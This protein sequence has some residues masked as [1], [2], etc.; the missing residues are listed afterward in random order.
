MSTSTLARE[1]QH[2]KPSLQEKVR[3]RA[4]ELYVQRGSQAGSGA[5]LDDRLCVEAEILRAQDAASNEASE[6]LF[7]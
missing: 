7:Q 5:E 3:R 4:Y 1:P 6:D 2:D